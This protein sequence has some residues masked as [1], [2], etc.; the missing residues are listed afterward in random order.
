MEDKCLSVPPLTAHPTIFCSNSRNDIFADFFFFLINVRPQSCPADLTA[1]PGDAFA[2]MLAPPQPHQ[3]SFRPLSLLCSRFK[4]RCSVSAACFPNIGCF[5]PQRC[6]LVYV[7]S[8][9]LTMLSCFLAETFKNDSPMCRITKFFIQ[10]HSVS[11]SK[12]LIAKLQLKLKL[13]CIY[14]F[15]YIASS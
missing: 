15:I 10:S 7:A 6:V 11:I 13:L 3:S 1:N 9:L 2:V 12:Y 5:F 4:R 8:R 14:L